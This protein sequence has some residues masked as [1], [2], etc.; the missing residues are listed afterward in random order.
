M[1]QTERLQE[2]L[3]ELNAKLGHI[4]IQLQQIVRDGCCRQEL[5][6]ILLLD[7]FQLM[8]QARVKLR[9]LVGEDQEQQNL[10]D[11]HFFEHDLFE[12]ISAHG[13]TIS[14]EFKSDRGNSA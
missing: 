7:H 12:L 4:T 1:G 6:L 2:E 10:L 13:I 11:E 3:A 9:E 8:E 14:T 5:L